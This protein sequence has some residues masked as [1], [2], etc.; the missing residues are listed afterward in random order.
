MPLKQ[1]STWPKFPCLCCAQAGRYGAWQADMHRCAAS[2]AGCHAIRAHHLY[3][4]GE[5]WRPTWTIATPLRYGG[6]GRSREH[7][8]TPLWQSPRPQIRPACRRFSPPLPAAE[9]AASHTA[10][11]ARSMLERACD[12]SL[13][14]Q[15]IRWHEHCSSD[16]T[17]ACTAWRYCMS[18]CASFEKR[19]CNRM[20]NMPSNL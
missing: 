13:V 17:Q 12:R 10:H 3:G 5:H 15:N 1:L 16:I 7:T 19:R 2:T 20:S 14:Q 4:A 6:H 8:S 18:A 11:Q 9:S